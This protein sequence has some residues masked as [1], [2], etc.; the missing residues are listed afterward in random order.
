MANDQ[1]LFLVVVG[2]DLAGPVVV[3]FSKF[4]FAFKI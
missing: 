2:M 1:M 3:Q 4:E